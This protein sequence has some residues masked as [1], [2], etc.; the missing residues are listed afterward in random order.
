MDKEKVWI[1]N[2][3]ENKLEGLTS[4]G[5]GNYYGGAYVALYKGDYVITCENYDG[6]HGRTISKEFYEA[7]E[8]EFGKEVH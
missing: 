7:C 4:L 2:M 1:S 3:D 5:V 6:I 8:K